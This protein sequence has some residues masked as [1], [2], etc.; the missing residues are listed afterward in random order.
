MAMIRRTPITRVTPTIMMAIIAT[1]GKVE[2]CGGVGVTVCAG[3]DVGS[4][5]EL[6]KTITVPSSSYCPSSMASCKECKGS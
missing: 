6:C 3:V 1:I 5:E 2:D 4:D